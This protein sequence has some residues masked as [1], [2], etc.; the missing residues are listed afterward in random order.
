VDPLAVLARGYAVVLREDD[1]SLV[2]SVQQ[3]AAGDRLRVRV[4]DGTFGAEAKTPASGNS[5]A[6]KRDPQK[7][8]R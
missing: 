8:R 7:Q 2:R 1:L 6:R 5:R 3:V 4:S